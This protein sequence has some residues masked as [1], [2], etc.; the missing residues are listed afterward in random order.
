MGDTGA[1]SEIIDLCETDD[2]EKSTK[3]DQD[4]WSKSYEKPK[5]VSETTR[6]TIIGLVI[7][8]LLAIS[9]VGA[10]QFAQTAVQWSNFK[11]PFFTT[12]FSTCWMSL[13]FPG[14]AL[15]VVISER[16]RK[17][18]A[19]AME[20]ST[21]LFG[22]SRVTIAEFFKM[23]WTLNAVWLAVNY[24]YI[25]GLKFIY[26]TDASAIM[27]SNVA[28]VYILSLCL[29]HEKLY[30]IRIVASVLCISGVVLFAYAKGFQESEHMLQGVLMIIASAFGAA[31]YK[32]VFKKIMGNASLGQVSLFLSLLGIS[33]ICIMWTINV[34]LH[35]A[36]VENFGFLDIP[37]LALILSA[38]LS[39]VFNFL[40]NFGIAYTYPLF[41]SIAMMIGI[42]LNAGVDVVVRHGT[43]SSLRL[44][45]AVLV[46]AGFA[47]MLFPDSWNDPI[48]SIVGCKTGNQ[49]EGK[50]EELVELKKDSEEEKEL[51]QKN[52][53]SERSFLCAEED[54]A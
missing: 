41:I 21:H 46:F 4:T 17:K 9:W 33:N 27:A 1:N 28:F 19:D 30:A 13:C 43:F 47:I 8:V 2:N 45:A 22:P 32:V 11:A 6:K 26:A 53:S 20:K 10:Q 35:V 52:K 16:D 31:V 42:P 36:E 3:T 38:I 39:L 49:E 40:V 29:L 24:L 37:W 23:I 54:I 15:F 34:C 48:H 51:S 12:W 18:I 44:I 5:C 50:E 25:F 14:Y 7:V